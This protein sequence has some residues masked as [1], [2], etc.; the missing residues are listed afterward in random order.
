MLK[1]VCLLHEFVLRLIEYDLSCWIMFKSSQI[2]VVSNF[3]KSVNNKLP[4]LLF[5]NSMI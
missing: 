4:F 3:S 1:Q 2:N 5:T